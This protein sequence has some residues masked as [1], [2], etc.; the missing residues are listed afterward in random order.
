MTEPTFQIWN[1]DCITE[2]PSGSPKR[3][4]ICV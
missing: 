4:L 2:W 3:P 1:E